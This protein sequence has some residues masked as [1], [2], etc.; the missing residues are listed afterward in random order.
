MREIWNKVLFTVK[1]K[2]VKVKHVVV[3]L[4]LLLLLL[5]LQQCTSVKDDDQKKAD[6]IENV[7]ELASINTDEL[8]ILLER[9]D[10]CSEKWYEDYEDYEDALVEQHKL[11]KKHEGKKQ[12][13]L[14]KKQEVLIKAVKEFKEKETEASVNALEKAYEEYRTYAKSVCK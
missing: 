6:T 5:L 7:C 8:Q 11:L 3:V 1:T 2:E 9:S 10:L 13:Q 12:K 4:L 14:Y